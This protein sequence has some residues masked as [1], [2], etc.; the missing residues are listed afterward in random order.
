MAERAVRSGHHGGHFHGGSRDRLRALPA[1]QQREPAR[2]GIQGELSGRGAVVADSQ[3]GC[4]VPV[5][6]RHTRLVFGQRQRVQLHRL[7]QAGA[8]DQR[9]AHVRD[10]RR[11]GEVQREELRA[12]S[13]GSGAP[14]GE[15]RHAGAHVDST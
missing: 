12:L 6:E 15:I 7:V 14:G 5:P 8:L 4:G 3:Q 2:P 1:R 13:A 11:G 10:Q 9:R